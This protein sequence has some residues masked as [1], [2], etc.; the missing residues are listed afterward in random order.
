MNKSLEVGNGVEGVGEPPSWSIGAGVEGSSK[1]S[2]VG[3]GVEGIGEP[4][5]WSIGAGVEGD[6][7][8]SSLSRDAL[9]SIVIES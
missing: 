2:E 6:S 5:S 8:C 7:G 3:N 1:C 4:P 9:S